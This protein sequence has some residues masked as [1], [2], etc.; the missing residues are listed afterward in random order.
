MMH[1]ALVHWLP[2]Q[3][4]GRD[5]LPPVLRLV[6]LSRFPEDGPRWPDGAW[7]VELVFAQPP[8]EGRGDVSQAMVDFAFDG[9]PLERLRAGARFALYQGPMKIADVE[10]LN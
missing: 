5:C 6:A 8:A 9:A 10:V 1:S 2:P 3:E 7:S 4:I